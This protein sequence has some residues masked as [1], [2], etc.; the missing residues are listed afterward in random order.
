MEFIILLSEEIL[1]VWCFHSSVCV[2]G[3]GWFG[4]LVHVCVGVWGCY[5]TFM[6]VYHVYVHAGTCAHV[7]TGR[8]EV[9]LGCV[10]H[11]DA[12]DLVKQGLALT[13]NQ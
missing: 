11:S 9:N 7:L 13:A 10:P 1:T 4:V 5:S 12:V 8:P 6:Y 2:W 3:E